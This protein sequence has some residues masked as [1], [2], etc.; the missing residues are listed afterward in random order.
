MIDSVHNKRAKLNSASVGSDRGRVSLSIDFEKQ[1]TTTSS[2]VPTRHINDDWYDVYKVLGKP[3]NTVPKSLRY[4]KI[5]AM[6]Y[7][8][9]RCP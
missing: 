6:N 7:Y 4:L 5:D 2:D 1:G 3:V 9:L 8:P